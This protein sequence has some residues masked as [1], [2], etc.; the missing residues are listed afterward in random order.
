M[1]LKVKYL[2]FILFVSILSSSA[3]AQSG[4][5]R[6]KITD[7]KTGEPLIGATVLFKGTQRGSTSDLDGLFSFNHLKPGTY[8]ITAQYVSFSPKTIANVKIYNDKVTVLDIRLNP[9]S[10]GLKEVIVKGKAVNRSE[11]AMLT[12]QKKSSNVIEG[13]SAQ[14]MSK[15]GDSDAAGALKRVTGINVVDGKYVYIRGLN[16][17]YSKTTLNNADIP[18]LDPNKYTVQMDIF[19]SSLIENIVV[20]KSFSPDLSGDFT[21]GLVNIDTRDFPEQFI[22]EVGAGIGYNSQ[23]TFNRNF[24]GYQGS[25]T[26]FLGFDNGFRRIP[27]DASGVLPQYPSDKQLL[28]TITESFNK[29][30]APVKEPSGPNGNI[31]FAIGN[32]INIGKHQ[33]GYIIGLSYKKE[34]TF[35][36]NGQK[37][38]FHL[39]GTADSLLITDHTYKDT[40]G[41]KEYLWGLL[42]NITYKFSGNHKIGLSVFKNQSG[43]STARYLFGQQ[44]SDDP[45]L[46]LQTRVLSWMERSLN[47]IQLKGAHYFPSLSRLKANWIGSFTYSYQNEPDMRF[48]TNSYY[49]N[50]SGIYKYSIQPSIYRVPARY[51]RYLN[52][53]NTNFKVNFILPLG[54]KENAPKLKFGGAYVYK[55]RNFNDKRIDYRFQF[56]QYVYDGNPDN[57]FSNKNIGLNYPGYDPAT[58]INF[59]LYIQGNPGD[60]LRNSYTA[61]QNIGAAYTM[62][63]VLLFNKLRVTTGV[64]FEHTIIEAASKDKSLKP[65][66]LN[67]NDFLPALNLTYYLSENMNLRFNSSRTLARPSFRELAPYASQDFAGGEIYVGNSH[68]KRTLINNYDLRWEYYRKPGEVISVSA[69]YK[70]FTNPIELVDNP[71][72][73]NTELSWDNVPNATV[74]GTEID[75]RKNLDFWKLTKNLKVGLNFTYVYSAVSIDSLELSAIRATDPNAKNYRPMNG[76]SPYIL[77]VLLGYNNKKSGTEATLAYNVTGPKLRITVKGGTPNIYQQPFNSL[78]FVFK[79][80]L[81]GNFGLTFKASNLLN[82]A[83]KETYS[84]K[85]KVYIY[86]KYKTGTTFEIGIKYQIRK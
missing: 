29:I 59:G 78:N 70:H 47:N 1:K 81:K 44:P 51:Y 20:Y 30:M 77:N 65:G 41:T 83:F 6:G 57:F 27:R 31:S 39:G 5:L 56:S 18:G 74:Y 68:L 11:A 38:L 67:N 75:I 66:Y 28:T 43:I 48:L 72:A 52:E 40:R 71:R 26:D 13:L 86:R 33:L 32:Q 10:L 34:N 53:L 14:Q 69:F 7:A 12:M 23:A 46:Y 42:G 58:G 76:Q 22:L 8:T 25:T 19:P 79:K 84:F 21:G 85:N 4:I 35:Y 37:N 16:D 61:K 49:P 62:I 24:I 45:E 2:S 36:Q 73:Q 80:Q 50:L 9:V 17:R 64:R 3:M 55:H 15:T 54:K 63:E 82:A 60:D